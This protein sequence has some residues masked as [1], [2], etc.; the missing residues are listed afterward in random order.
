VARSREEGYRR[1]AHEAK[2]FQ[3]AIGRAFDHQQACDWINTAIDD[4]RAELEAE[5]ALDREIDAWDM[6][7]R[8]MFMLMVMPKRD[9]II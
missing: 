4:G 6:S 1:G 2:L 5:H 3:L 7:C 8:I 9:G